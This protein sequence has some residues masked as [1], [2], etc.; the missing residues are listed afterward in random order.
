[1][2]IW[3]YNI[4]C[5]YSSDKKI[6]GNKNEMAFDENFRSIMLRFIRRLKW[7]VQKIRQWMSNRKRS[8]EN[9]FKIKPIHPNN[10]NTD[11]TSTCQPNQGSSDPI[12]PPEPHLTNKNYNSYC[13]D[14][15][16]RTAAPENSRDV[17]SRGPMGRKPM[18]ALPQSQE[19]IGSSSGI[20][21]TPR[22]IHNFPKHV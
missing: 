6:G 12:R 21:Y 8:N 22:K 13:R 20:Q 10:Q 2:L 11:Q 1:M 3:I 17:S 4:Q 7:I 16:N 18:L 15:K 5:S 9:G 19:S 14:Q